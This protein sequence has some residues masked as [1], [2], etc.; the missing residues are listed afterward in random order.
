MA[1]CTAP[2]HQYFLPDGDIVWFKLA[3]RLR[4]KQGTYIYKIGPAPDES[5]CR[6]LWCHNGKPLTCHACGNAISKER[7][8]LTKPTRRGSRPRGR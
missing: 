4:D 8:A 6:T 5:V 2:W 1:T 7:Y 3:A